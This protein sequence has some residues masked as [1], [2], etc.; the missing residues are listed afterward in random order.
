MKAWL[1]YLVAAV[2]GTLIIVRILL[3]DIL[4]DNTSLLLLLIGITAL[5]LPYLPDYVESL[6][7]GSTK[8]ELRRKEMEQQ[9]EIIDKQ[10][11]QLE[12]QNEIIQKIVAFSMSFHIY[13]HIQELHK[14]S[15]MPGEMY[16]YRRYHKQDMYFLRD[17]GYIEKKTDGSEQDNFLRIGS[18]VPEQTNLLDVV[19]LTP[20]GTLYFELRELFENN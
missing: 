18:L 20:A 12:H 1:L 15:Q 8:V 17:H 5:L 19:K 6:A 11:N 4:I 2:S 16:L 10:A 7:F 13:K 9:R 3:P 14:K